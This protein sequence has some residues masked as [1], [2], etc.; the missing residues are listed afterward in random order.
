[1]IRARER[2]ARGARTA[3]RSIAAFAL[4]AAALATAC[5]GGGGGNDAVLNGGPPFRVSGAMFAASGSAIDSDTSDPFAPFVSNDSAAQAQEIPNPV[6]LGGHV[7]V[8]GRGAPQGRTTAAGDRQD[9]FRVSIANGQTIRLQIAENGTTNNLDLE[10]RDLNETLVASSTSTTRTEEIAVTT[11]GD[12]YVVVIAKSGS[13][14]YTLT[15]GQSQTSA[16]APAA[17]PEFVPGQVI[18][19]YRD[20]LADAKAARADATG[21]AG[22]VGMRHVSGTS[23]GPVLLAAETLA[24]RRAAFQALGLELTPEM[25]GAAV[26]RGT[27]GLR[28]DTRRIAAALRRRSDV[29][30]ADL[31]YVRHA[32]AVPTDQLYPF[33]WHYAHINLP[34]AWDITAPNSGIVVAVLDTGVKAGHPD[35][36]G[37][38][39]PGFDFI[40]DPAVAGD[41]DGCDA[42]PDDPGDNGPSSSFH[43]THVTGTIA[44]RTSFESGNSEGV[45]GVAWNARVMPLRVLGIGGGTDADIMAALRYAAGRAGTCAGAGAAT[46]ARIVNMSL[47]GPGF[48][49]TFQDLITDLRT[50]NHLIIVASAGNEASSQA[51]YP[52]A[53]DGV[54]AV[55]AVG[56]TNALAPYSSFGPTIDVAAPGGDFQRDADGDG[57]PDGVLSTFFDSGSGYGYAFFQGTSMAAP[58]VSGVIALML[59][60]NPALTPFDIDNALNAGL[61][62]DDIGSSQLFGNGLIDAVKAVN[63]AAQGGGGATV[64]DPVLRVA[65]DSL[66]YGFLATSLRI[67]ATNGGNEQQP[68]TVTGVTFTSDDGAP[69]LTVTPETVDAQGLGDYR[70]V[71]NRTGRPDGIYTGRIEFDSDRNT[72]VVPVIMQVGDPTSTSA[73]AGHQYVLLVDPVTFDT[74]DSREA[75]PVGGIYS[76]SFSG[77]APGDYLLIAGTDVDGDDLVCD[78]GEACGAF[79][80]TETI[81]PI[82]VDGNRT[83]LTFVTG[84]EADISTAAAGADAQAPAR[85]GYSHLVGGRPPEGE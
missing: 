36:T 72:V 59:G 74:I 81:V 67:S 42:N 26:S 34:Q 14:N 38:L 8:P 27:R 4:A 6:T 64:L 31:N 20:A 15:I 37:Q 9:W 63:F 78:T 62:T 40:S 75:D 73:N 56:P 69:W 2:S 66:N 32:N 19:R 35:L 10:L 44:A 53:Y 5:G 16:S 80:T 24:E 57:Y 54:I 17:E 1:M 41:G 84:F 45:A 29:R 33:Q 82:T 12:Y 13:S 46:P 7:N 47:G 55:S 60:I 76:F 61:I 79:P 52:A 77:V 23:D 28:D 11:T 49:Q 58:H 25:R 65:P 68:L 50:T 18:V 51:M 83:G 43:G 22:R 48:S 21:L 39:V 70:A 71:V 3:R 30:S 85:R